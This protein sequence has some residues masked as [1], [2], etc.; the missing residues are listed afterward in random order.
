MFVRLYLIALTVFLAIDM[1]WLTL[2]AKNFYAKQIGFLMAKTPNLLAALI[3]YLIFIAGLIFFVITP[4]L[5]KKIWTQALLAG[6][7]FGLVTYA[8]YDLTNLATVKDWPLIITI[9]DLIWGMVL[10]ASVSVITYFIAH[11]LGI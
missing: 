10:S 2:I 11:K 7:F 9:V 4:A 8:T 3:F 5:D 6:A 1:V